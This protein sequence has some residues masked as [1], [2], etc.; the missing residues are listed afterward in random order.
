[1][2]K[3]MLD[4]KW[5]YYKGE[6]KNIRV[7]YEN[8]TDVL[9]Y[10]KGYNHNH[11]VVRHNKEELYKG[12]YNYGWNGIETI[13]LSSWSQKIGIE[14]RS[15]GVTNKTLYEMI[16]DI[17]ALKGTLDDTGD[18]SNK[19]EKIVEKIIDI[20]NRHIGNIIFNQ[21]NTIYHYQGV[22]D[23]IMFFLTAYSIHYSDC[24]RTPINDNKMYNAIKIIKYPYVVMRTMIIKSTGEIFVNNDVSTDTSALFYRGYQK[25]ETEDEAILRV[26][27]IIIAG[28]THIE[29]EIYGD[30]SKERESEIKDNILREMR[31]SIEKAEREKN[32]I[33]NK[34]ILE[35]LSDNKI[36]NKNF[37]NV[38]IMDI[39]WAC[40]KETKKDELIKV[41]RPLGLN[42]KTEEMECSDCTNLSDN[43]YIEKMNKKWD[44]KIN[45]EISR[46]FDDE[47]YNEFFKEFEKEFE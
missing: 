14:L 3:E 33:V 27:N 46:E 4:I 11:Y 20:L 30:I 35:R 7:I 39:C 44:K 8:G 23:I 17:F 18:P 16:K 34:E 10:M 25:V 43:E 29:K 41:Y 42:E 45:D 2:V 37:K 31:N 28:I 21:N 12:R 1:M 36:I 6:D 26:G 19:N 9:Y 32:A 24:I 38:D 40:E 22:Q 13:D 5:F 47:I 15:K